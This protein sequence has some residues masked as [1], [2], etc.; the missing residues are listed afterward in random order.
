MDESK[1]VGNLQRW[2]EVQAIFLRYGFD[3][4]VA[5][6]NARWRP[7]PARDHASGSTPPELARL[8]AP[9]RLRL[10]LEE[11]GPTYIKFGQVVSSQASM[12]PNDWLRELEKLQDA[13]PPFPE[14]QVRQALTRELGAQPEYLF[15]E[16]DFTPLAAASIGQVHAALTNDYEPVVVKIQRPNIRPQIHADLAIM[17][18]VARG[19]ETTMSW[20]RN[21][22]AVSIIDEFGAQLERE[23]DYRNEAR[24]MDRIRHNLCK[25]RGIR[26]P[27]VYWS[28]V[29][30]KVLTMER[31]P[32]QKVTNPDALVAPG[33]DRSRLA[34]VF[35]RAM[36]QQLLIDGFFH[37]DV[38]PG[39]VFVNPHADRAGSGGEI[40]LIDL[41]MTGSLDETQ[42]AELTNL[43]RGLAQRNSRRITR[44]VIALGEPFRLVDETALERDISGLVKRHLSGS[45]AQ[46]SYA[47]FLSDLLA[48][49]FDN[50]IRVP[51]DLMFALKAIMQT[52]QIVRTMN[53]DYGI[54]DLAR[55][56]GAQ[57]LAHQMRP[58]ALQDHIANTVDQVVRIAPLVGDALEQ[59][60]YDLKKGKRVTRLDPADVNHLSRLMTTSVTRIVLA[61]LIAALMLSSVAMLSS[62]AGAAL[63][64]LPIAGVIGFVVSL[65]LAAL[66]AVS[67]LWKE[68]RK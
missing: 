38:H 11:L 60:V 25:V 4:L 12:I 18:E 24:N 21:Y 52:E 23:L 10:M 46:L 57:V 67:L 44:T 14:E 16:F 5:Q 27:R 3:F 33:M 7:R 47:R 61:L 58:S 29:T 55:M 19:L 30:D 36:V 49:F 39:N 34:R 68:W 2:W 48:V 32:G 53:P 8:S 59:Y 41:G 54:T 45:L 20:A 6:G 51:S 35:I 56:A 15:R 26:T 43:L 28:L 31:A 13:V 17:R 62:P 22:G 9:Q 50:G 37:A 42:R 64:F 1:P 66:M 63:A 65:V 40:I